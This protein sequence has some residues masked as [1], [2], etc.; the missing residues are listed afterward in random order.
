MCFLP[1]F[2]VIYSSEV[3]EGDI[4]WAEANGMDTS[5]WVTTPKEI[6]KLFEELTLTRSK[7][8]TETSR[9]CERQLNDMTAKLI[10]EEFDKLFL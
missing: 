10:S 1:F 6:G 3:I 5:K 2:T 7:A 9:S 8:I 4:E